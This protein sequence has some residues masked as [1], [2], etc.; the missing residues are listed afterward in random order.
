MT[1]VS[2]QIGSRP[3]H[4]GQVTAGIAQ[5]DGLRGIAVIAVVLYHFAATLAPGGFVGVDIFFVVSGFLIGGILW[6][7]LKAHDK[8]DFRAFFVRRIRRLAPAYFAMAAAS[9][10]AAYFIL[11][12][13]EFRAFAKSLIASV[14]Y[15]SNV[16][17]FR[18]AGY[19]DVASEDKVLL[20]TWSLSV[21]E[22]FYLC[23][24]L[25]FV[26]LGGRRRA[27]VAVLTVVLA[28][29]LLA[30]IL[31]TPQSPTAAFFLFPF[32]AWELVL[33]VLLAIAWAER[34][35][36]GS[37]GAWVSWLGLGLVAAAIVLTRPDQAFPG[38][39]ALLPT[40]GAALLLLNMSHRNPVNAALA[41]PPL[42]QMGLISYSLYLWHWPVL[43]LSR[44]YYQ[45]DASG[46]FG[47]SLT[48]AATLVIATLSWRFVER[49]VREAALPPFRLVAGAALGSG[50]LLAAGTAV[51]IANGLPA[52]FGPVTRA[53]IEA[54]A[55]FI[56]DWRRCKTEAAGPLA[57]V[58][59]CRV[60]AEGSPTFLVWG[61]SHVRAF[62]EGIDQA[63][64]EAGASGLL[65]WRAGCP[66]L[67]DI[68]KQE[69]AAT[70]AQ[71]R[72]CSE[73]NKVV[74]EALPRLAGIETILLIGRWSYYANGAGTGVDAANTIQ[75]RQTSGES[76]GSQETLFFNATVATVEEIRRAI[77]QVF[78]MQQT[79]E[80]PYY[81][82]RD[83]ARRL[84]HGRDADIDRTSLAYPL[85]DVLARLASSEAPFL[86]LD[87]DGRIRLLRLRDRFCDRQQCS[88]M[89]DGRSYYFD[90]NH[91]TNSAARAVKGVLTPVLAMQAAPVTTSNNP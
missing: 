47:T 46:V 84:A 18:E 71:D 24:P 34:S 74:R 28:S 17:F 80:M 60:G 48:L 78:V 53:H 15:L 43:T 59:V 42:V 51:Y 10:V 44:Y 52:R 79:P 72:A 63:A 67:F 45:D 82:S 73:A 91:I 55:D 35:L 50:L 88:V 76:E 38:Y 41:W 70:P 26:V 20:H 21:E 58:E 11:L 22:Q 65:I 37:Y 56:Q 68:D 16:Q 9:S 85:K 64:S 62:K 29:S 32:R 13:F 8:I 69:S 7:E 49:P 12:P 33:G 77:P 36:T 39:M 30:C 6:R 23:L 66:P 25:L 3:I 40:L 5:I 89:H 90:N 87:A 81:D 86:T 31:V 4:T 1:H 2:A 83:F 54:S 75:I 14:F 61:D 27:L 57:G 19:F